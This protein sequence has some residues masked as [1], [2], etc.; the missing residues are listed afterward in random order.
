[1]IVARW[2]WFIFIIPSILISC[3]SVRKSLLLFPTY[4]FPY[5]SLFI[6]VWSMDSQ[7][8][9]CIESDNP[10]HFDA[11]IAPAL[12][13]RS[14]SKLTH[15]L[16]CSWLVFS[17]LWPWS[18]WMQDGC[19]WPRTWCVHCHWTALYSR[20]SEQKNRDVCVCVCVSHVDFRLI[21]YLP[22]PM[23]F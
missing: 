23:K 4:K 6:S 11:Q 9:E 17:L 1:M 22:V 21:P 18:F 7:V 12:V 13:S 15:V 5:I 20:P 3:H 14:L 8:I 10:I 2:W 16:I 19:S